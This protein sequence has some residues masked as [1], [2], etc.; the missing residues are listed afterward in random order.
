MWYRILILTCAAT[1]GHSAAFAQESPTPPPQATAAVNSNP[2][3]EDARDKI[4]FS[5]ETE[6]FKPLVAKLTR[7]IVMDQKE[8][9]TSPFRMNRRNA[10]WWMGLTGVTA[11]LIL[12]DDWTSTRLNNSRGQVRWGGRV[13]QVG[14]SYTLIP[15]VAGF[16]GYGAWKDDAKAR[17]AGILGAEALI[18]SLIVVQAL[19]YAAGRARP[20]ENKAG[21]FF[22]GGTSFPSGHAIETWSLASV[23]A[24]E[25]HSNKIVPIVVYG[26]AATISTSRIVA[27]RHFA[28]DVVLGAGMGW[29]IG[30]YVFKTHRDHTLHHHAMAPQ[31]IPTMDAR[32]R[33]YGVALSWGA[34]QPGAFQSPVPYA[35]GPFAIGL[36]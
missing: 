18:D 26:L 22:Q 30:R 24:H 14:A 20:D 12:S 27:Q 6:R 4:L 23:L 36:R 19:K 1:F 5:S 15:L 2:A 25:Y 17:E 10:G 7:N 32:T 28:S 13:S 8:I 11:G 16:Y 3:S 9:W 34:G 21:D 31:V 33:T 29:F 35:R